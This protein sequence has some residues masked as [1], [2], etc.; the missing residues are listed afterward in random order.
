MRS[1][2]WHRQGVFA[3]VREDGM[4]SQ[5]LLSWQAFSRDFYFEEVGVGIN[6]F[7]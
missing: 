3:V 6:Y 2:S 4:F 7:E 5:L 1:T